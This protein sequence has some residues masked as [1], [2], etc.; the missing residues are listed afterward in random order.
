[1][2]R[3]AT[4]KESFG[5]VRLGL[6]KNWAQFSLLVLVNAFVGGMVGVERTVLPLLA[7]REFEL[8][9]RVAMLNFIA[10]FGLT[11]A[12]TNLLAGRVSDRIGR[13]RVLL[14]GWL[15][16]LPVPIIIMLAPEWS[17][18]VFANVLLGINQG[19][20]WSTTVIMKID[21]VGPNRRGLAMGLNEAAGYLAV[22]LAAF[23][24]GYLAATTSLRP[25][26]F[27]LGL[28]FAFAGLLIS[29]FF[30]R[31][32]KD[33]T[34][35]EANQL[36]N[37]TSEQPT[38]AAVFLLTSWRNKT[39]FASSQAGMINNLNDGMAWGLFP[40]FFA[41]AGLSLEEISFLVAIYPA[42]WGLLQ[43]ITGAISDYTGRK[44]MI[45]SGMLI[46]AVGI[47]LIL[48]TDGFW[49]WINTSIL[50]GLGT[51]MVYPTLLAIVGDVTH[52]AW[53]TTAVGVY[54]LWRDFGYVAGALLSGAIA[55]IFG[56]RWAIG[57]V[58]VLTFGSGLLC[59]L[60]MNELKQ[61]QKL[62]EKES[63]PY[64]HSC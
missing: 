32:T 24:A 21:L 8:A 30:V 11:K 23:G 22:A 55:D 40:L 6:R 9:S 26:P 2:N 16:G 50:L 13:K 59:A 1:M 41:S 47:W 39:L 34:N 56:L 3:L 60:L 15:A 58:G 46:Q 10:S 42:V 27:L 57:V 45:A 25:Q 7:D 33:F 44:W 12:L 29:A 43:L 28:F 62:R 38:F 14:A 48:L 36:Q 64:S 5:A 51:A 17:W 54:R 4:S 53:R 35:I 19:L 20:C 49:S 18:V 63:N 61:R 31:E 52:P 37:Q